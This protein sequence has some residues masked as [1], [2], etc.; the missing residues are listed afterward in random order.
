LHSLGAARK[1]TIMRITTMFAPASAA[2]ALLGA[3]STSTTASP[4]VACGPDNVATTNWDVVAVNDYE[5][6]WYYASVDAIPVAFYDGGLLDAGAAAPSSTAAA[7]AVAAAV[8]TYFP[9]GCATASASGNV[10][11]FMLHNCTGPL[12]LIAAT[13]TVTATLT[14]GVGMVGV[15]L[16]GNNI[17]ANGATINLSTSGTLIASNGQKTLTSNTS[18]TGTGPNGNSA[19]H[20]GMYMIVWTPGSGCATING[21]LNGA[22]SGGNVTS[23]QIT[24]YVTCANKC[25][26]S[27]TSVSSFNGGSV[28]LTFNGTSSAQCAA[29]NG[30]SATVP[31]RCR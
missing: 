8:G 21:T 2:I 3:C 18:T 14:L 27:G 22:G 25:P 6:S 20:S 11:T 29:S 16:A 31:L 15:Q 5:A 9:N 1:E 12:D 7:S 19:S 10:V 4:V 30:T 13:G 28:T 24:N 23:T 26:Q 17:S